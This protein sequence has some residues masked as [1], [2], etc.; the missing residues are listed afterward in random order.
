MTPMRVIAEW[1]VR[2]VGAA[3]GAL[4]SALL[5]ALLYWTVIGLFVG[6]VGIPA[7]A[8]AAAVYAP[9]ILRASRPRRRVV[10]A[11]SLA[12][13]VGVSGLLVVVILDVLGRSSPSI[14]DLILWSV[15]YAISG[16]LFG[17]PGALIVAAAATWV[18]R[19]IPRHVELLWPIAVVVVLFVI[20]ATATAAF[21]YLMD[22]ASRL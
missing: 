2:V 18:G 7:G 19:R 15:L 12:T 14:A 17:M 6:A 21:L 22:V 10:E 8:L 13:V 16:V 4:F 5:G 11:A 3:L 9:T 1:K 20:G